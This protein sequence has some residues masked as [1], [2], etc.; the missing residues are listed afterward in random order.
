[1]KCDIINLHTDAINKGLSFNVTK[2]KY[3]IESAIQIRN[4]NMIEFQ[5]IT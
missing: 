4:K 5:K 3:C 1:M 2:K